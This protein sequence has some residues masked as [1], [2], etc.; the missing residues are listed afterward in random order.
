MSMLSNPTERNIRP[1][2]FQTGT[3][4]VKKLVLALAIHDKNVTM[5]KPT[6]AL[7][8]VQ[9]GPAP[10]FEKNRSTQTYRNNKLMHSRPPKQRFI[11]A[12]PINPRISSPT[13]ISDSQLSAHPPS[14]HQGFIKG[15]IVL[16][17]HESSTPTPLSRVWPDSC[18]MPIRI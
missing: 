11:I 2:M 7:T 16:H 5:A 1:L 18:A 14:A 13:K 4:T 8:T 6:R 3:C 10:P 12:M 17:K 9:A 15:A